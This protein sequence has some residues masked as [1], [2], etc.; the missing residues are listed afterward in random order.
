MKFIISLQKKLLQL[1]SF[2][3]VAI[4]LSTLFIAV[5]QIFLRNFFDIGIIWGD[6][7]LRIAVLW[8]GMMGALY[9][10]RRNNHISIDLG[11]KYLSKKHLKIVQ[12][13][14]HLFTSFICGLVAWYS[15]H[16]I[17]IEYEYT[18]IAFANVPV[19]LSMIIIPLVFSI[20]SLRYLGFSLLTIC[21]HDIHSPFKKELTLQKNESKL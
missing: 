7:F 12:S 19:W 21:S 9:A 10:S 20:M 1:E 11:V 5:L 16:L 2:L 14:I 17:V 13:I 3:L 6:S 4:F 15:I 18:E 8:I